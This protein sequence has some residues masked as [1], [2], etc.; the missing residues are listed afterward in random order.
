VLF[1]PLDEKNC[2][3]ICPIAAG[4]T[5]VCLTAI[6]VL[7]VVVTVGRRGTIADNLLA[8]DA[9]LFLVATLTSYL[10]LRVPDGQRLHRMERV[11]DLSFIGAMVLLTL[12]CFVITFEVTL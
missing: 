10:A 9:L 5:G 4:M 12:V 3:V 7:R 1:R 6:T 11:A 8:L 2:Q